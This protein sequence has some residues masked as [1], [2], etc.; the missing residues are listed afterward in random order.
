M[1]VVMKQESAIEVTIGWNS[2]PG[3]PPVPRPPSWPPAWMADI[4]PDSMRAEVANK[5]PA[6]PDAE[7][8]RHE[9]HSRPCT[10]NPAYVRL[11]CRKCGETLGPDRKVEV[12]E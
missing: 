1:K 8:C 10:D 4:P 2:V 7:P 11:E 9:P 12:G 6:K 3:V 5:P